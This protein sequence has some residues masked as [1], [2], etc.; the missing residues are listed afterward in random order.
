MCR[1]LKTLYGDDVAV[2]IE[3]ELFA[4]AKQYRFLLLSL[5]SNS[6]HAPPIAESD[7]ISAPRKSTSSK[8]E[9]LIL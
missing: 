1:L 3:K 4:V 6:E 5:N 7:S 2:L 9:P 8:S